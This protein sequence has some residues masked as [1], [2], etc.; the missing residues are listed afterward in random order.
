MNNTKLTPANIVIMAGAVVAF[1]ASFFPFYES[2]FLG[3]HKSVNAWSSHLFIIFT[4]PALLALAMGIVAAV[5]SFASGVT[6]PARVLGFSLNQVHVILGFQATLMMFAAAIV[7]YFGLDKGFG[8][9]LM[10]LGAI[11]CLVG[12]IMRIVAGAPAAPPAG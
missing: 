10:L 7:D 4:L 8:L 12:A 2:S 5:E 1:L 11:A 9:Y 3:Y 6:L